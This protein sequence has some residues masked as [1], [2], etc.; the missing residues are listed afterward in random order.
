MRS[1][2]K[3]TVPCWSDLL[4]SAVTEPGIVSTAFSRFHCYSVRNQLLALMQCSERGIDAGT[5]R[6]LSTMERTWAI[7]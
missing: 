5:T 4:R 1:Y 7:M 6:H 2:N 3:S